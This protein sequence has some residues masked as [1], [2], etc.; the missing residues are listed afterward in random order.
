M[1]AAEPTARYYRIICLV[2][3]TG[4]GKHDDPLRPE[5]V[6]A[7]ANA[8][9]RSGILAWSMQP[10]DDGKMAIL[11]LVAADHRAFDAL[12]NDKRP[13]I[14]VFEIGKQ[15]KDSIEKEMKKFRKDFDL[16]SFRVVAQ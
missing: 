4:S 5:Y 2:H 7:V 11:H 1:N 16:D 10:S 13:D 9:S 3:M 14:R 6:P 8:S 15:G 12:L